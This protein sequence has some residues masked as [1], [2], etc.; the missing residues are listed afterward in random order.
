MKAFD[1]LVKKVSRDEIDGEINFRTNS[2]IETFSSL[3]DDNLVPMCEF[4]DE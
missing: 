4:L 3:V 1:K 2:K